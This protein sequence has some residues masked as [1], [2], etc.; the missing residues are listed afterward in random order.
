MGARVTRKPR[1]LDLFC[2]QGG[3]AAG[4]AAAGFDVF[5]V[6]LDAAMLERYPYEHA[7]GDALAFLREHGGDFDAIHASPPCQRYSTITKSK[8]GRP[9]LIGRTRSIL[10]EL[11]RP[12]VIE[13]VEGAP[14]RVDLRL[15]ASGFGLPMRRHRIFESNVAMPAAPACDHWSTVG[16][17]GRDGRPTK[18]TDR[19][20]VGVY[21]HPNAMRGSVDQWL[22]A[23]ETSW[24]DRRGVTQAIPPAYTEFIG[25]DLAARVALRPARGNT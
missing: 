12:Y 18:S 9:D 13:N 16:E 7:S 10:A 22:A 4:Y 11:G 21:G 20:F 24:M 14:L 19:R 8:A 2:G 6:D 3:A 17:S 23:M 5:G 1:L 25:R 15:C